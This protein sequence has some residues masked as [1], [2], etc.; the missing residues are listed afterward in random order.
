MVVEEL[1]CCL[2]RPHLFLRRHRRRL[3]FFSTETRG[4]RHW[5]I[6]FRLYFCLMLQSLGAIVV[7]VLNGEIRY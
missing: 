1:A 4:D 2:F 6:V 3:F 5:S 7:V